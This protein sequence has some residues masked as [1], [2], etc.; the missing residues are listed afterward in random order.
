MSL[1]TCLRGCN[2]SWTK[3]LCLENWMSVL[4]YHFMFTAVLLFVCVTFAYIYCLY[5]SKLLL[6][7]DYDSLKLNP[8]RNPKS[9]QHIC[10]WCV[11]L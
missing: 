6:L 8:T 1:L 3:T 4:D 9:P 11:Y 10:Q 7:S 2:R 5:E